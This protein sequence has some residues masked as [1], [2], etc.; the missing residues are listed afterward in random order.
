[1]IENKSEGKGLIFSLFPVGK[2]GGG[3]NYTLN[4]AIS[5]SISGTKCDLVSPLSVEFHRLKNSER[6]L[7]V[8]ERISF[9]DGKQS[10]KDTLIFAN[11]L[12]IVPNHK[13]VWIHQHLAGISTYDLLLVTHSEQKVMFT[14][15]GAEQNYNDFWIRYNRLPNH[16]FAEVSKYSMSR[17]KKYTDNVF[18]IYGGVWKCSLEKYLKIPIKKNQH[19]V[20]VGRVLPH[21]SFEV[22]ISSLSKNERLIIIGPYEENVSYKHF[23]E[24]RA[25][26]KNVYMTGKIL[27]DEKNLI[28][29]ESV[30]LIAN[31]ST[32]TYKGHKNEQSELLG[33]VLIESIIH[34]T[35]P[36]SSNQPALNEVMLTLD[37]GE[38]VYKERD[39]ESLRAKMKLVSSLSS[40]KYQSMILRA[41]NILL[42]SFLWDDYW[43]RCKEM[44]DNIDL[45][46]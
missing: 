26:D 41:R 42:Q 4:C 9:R 34:G 21:K 23:L 38:L 11:I 39:I 29:S 37:L 8:F 31:S 36:I 45:H 14:N 33:L 1:M 6:F 2:T 12:N 22:A 46:N 43:L 30:A 15:H 32:M 16:F 13:Y 5:M 19:F 10:S 7:N 35:L 3:E 27:S 28:I 18:Y 40:Q 17:T 44:V 24:T 20:S 25:K